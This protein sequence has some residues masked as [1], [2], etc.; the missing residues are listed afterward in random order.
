MTSQSAKEHGR[1][2]RN[3]WDEI[4]SGFT[5]VCTDHYEGLL[6]TLRQF[7]LPNVLWKFFWHPCSFGLDLC[8]CVEKR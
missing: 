5:E 6:L 7:I 4:N 1:L 2:I 8:E 3:I